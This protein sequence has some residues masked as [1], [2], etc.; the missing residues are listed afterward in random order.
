MKTFLTTSVCLFG[1]MLF[2]SCDSHNTLLSV[3]LPAYEPRL[4]IQS[5]ASPQSG[6][7]AMI[8]YSRPTS[9]TSGI[10]PTLPELDVYIVES[11][12]KSYKLNRDSLGHYSLGASNLQLEPGVCYSLQIVNKNTG[13]VIKSKDVQLPPKPTVEIVTIENKAKSQYSF[14]LG[15]SLTNPMV[16]IFALSQVVTLID[17]NGLMIHPHNR[18][19]YFNNSLMYDV[20]QSNPTIKLTGSYRKMISNIELAE[21]IELRVAYFSEELSRFVRDVKEIDYFGEGIYH[22]VR[23]VYSNILGSAVGIFGLYN[24]IIIVEEL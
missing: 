14:D 23:P 5:V 6:A 9:G 12:N 21:S 16:N 22:T 13:E 1:I 7:V 10:P 15:I 19:S 3:D 4:V 8:Q 17:K 18:K 2:Q 11:G 20:K 24:E